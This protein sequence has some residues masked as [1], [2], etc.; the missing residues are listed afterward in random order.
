MLVSFPT[1]I[2]KSEVRLTGLPERTSRVRKK[3][4]LAKSQ[5]A[6]AIAAT[7]TIA[8][9]ELAAVLSRPPPS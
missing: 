9:A 1:R 5:P 3:A 7:S 2:G 6:I 8:D 4:L